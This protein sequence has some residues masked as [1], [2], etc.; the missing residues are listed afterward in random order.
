MAVSARYS[1]EKPPGEISVFGFDFSEL[2]PPGTGIASGSLTVWTN[3]VAPA[4]SSDWTIGPVAVQGRSLYATLG[5]G[6]EGTDYQLRWIATDTS[7]NVWPRIGLCL[8]ANT[9]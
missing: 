7:G 4:Q 6:V 1:P 2:I 8:V 3:T 9:S 5:G